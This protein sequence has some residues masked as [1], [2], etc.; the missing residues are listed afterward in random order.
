MKIKL[1]IPGEETIE[2][3]GEDAQ[4]FIDTVLNPTDPNYFLEKAREFCKKFKED[5][6]G[7]T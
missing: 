3:S 5:N 6:N 1:S 7:K 2:L 4:L